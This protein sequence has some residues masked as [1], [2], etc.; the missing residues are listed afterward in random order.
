M[1]CQCF[2]LSV[3]YIE[4]IRTLVNK[5]VLHTKISVQ[6][7]TICDQRK[8]QLLKISKFISNYLINYG[9]EY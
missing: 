6:I 7:R 4:F 3:Q 8:L 5:I 1:T 9:I 2:V